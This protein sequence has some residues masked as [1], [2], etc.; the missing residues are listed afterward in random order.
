MAA[1]NERVAVLKRGCFVEAVLDSALSIK[2]W[3]GAT[4][5]F[6]SGRWSVTPGADE[7][8]TV[9]MKALQSEN[10]EF[11]EKS[12]PACADGAWTGQGRCPMPVPPIL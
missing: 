2:A 9:V 8:C 10:F 4:E 11:V 1:N 7:D 6:Y 12:E 5:K 3:M